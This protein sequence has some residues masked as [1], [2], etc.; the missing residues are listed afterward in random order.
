MLLDLRALP[1][2]ILRAL[3]ADPYQQRRCAPMAGTDQVWHLAERTGGAE[4][5]WNDRI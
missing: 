5:I 1:R 4:T 3:P 2:E